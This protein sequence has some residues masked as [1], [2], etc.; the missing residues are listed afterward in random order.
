[1]KSSAE[2]YYLLVSGNKN[3]SV[4]KGNFDIQST[5]LEK[6]LRVKFDYM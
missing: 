3:V 1:M 4:R 5:R 2:K 6:L